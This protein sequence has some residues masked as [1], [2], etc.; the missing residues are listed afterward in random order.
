M[1][2]YVEDYTFIPDNILHSLGF[3]RWIRRHIRSYICTYVPEEI[4][5]KDKTKYA[6]QLL[7]CNY[8]DRITQKIAQLAIKKNVF[9]MHV[10]FALTIIDDEYHLRRD[11]TILFSWVNATCQCR[12]LDPYIDIEYHIREY[13]F[14]N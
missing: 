12:V 14:H 7:D 2:Q 13:Y 5:I 4:R 3:P 6:R 9:P 11:G 10:L 1:G 8:G